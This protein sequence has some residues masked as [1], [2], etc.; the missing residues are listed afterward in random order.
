MAGG[1]T[2]ANT[3]G[4]INGI[5]Q[6]GSGVTIPDT[7]LRWAQDVLFDNNGTLRR[8]SPWSI[9]RFNVSAGYPNYSGSIDSFSISSIAYAS[10]TVTL[11]F[12][13]TPAHNFT[14]GQPIIVSGV[15]VA[16]YNGSFV[17]TATTATTISYEKTGLTT[18]ASGGSITSG[19]ERII[20]T[21]ST[22]NPNGDRVTG[23]V[24]RSANK[25]RI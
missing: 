15:S 3:L 25:A 11:T 8:R 2:Y 14:I 18:P 9:F 7:F 20:S 12:P 23:M 1:L 19:S 16:G 21:I 10:P 22:V 5:N 4:S 17:V 13:S 6:S 24:L